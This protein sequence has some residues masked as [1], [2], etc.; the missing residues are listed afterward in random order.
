[1]PL[2]ALFQVFDG[3]SAVTAGILRARGK[4]V[5]GALLNLRTDWE[6]EVWKVTQRLKAQDKMERER[7]TEE[8]VERR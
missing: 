3:N 6:R 7:R 8:D 1:M 2:V 5:T 4:Q